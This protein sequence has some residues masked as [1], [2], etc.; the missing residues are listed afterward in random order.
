MKTAFDRD[1]ERWLKDPEFKKHY[2]TALRKAKANI[3]KARKE[4]K[5]K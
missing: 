4:A 2:K 1:L 5:K 3:A